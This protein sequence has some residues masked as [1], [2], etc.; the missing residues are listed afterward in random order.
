M[1][2]KIKKINLILF[3]SGIW[4]LAGFILLHRAYTWINLLSNTQLIVSLIIALF[5]AVIK[6]YFI[7]HKL[8]I[9]N[10]YRINNYEQEFI[11]ILKFHTVK[12]QLLIIL[13]IATG[14]ILRHS[15]Y[16]PKAFLMPIYIGIG[17]AMLYSATL[18]LLYVFKP[19]N[20]SPKN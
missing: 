10:I 15:P 9:K 16:I 7:F 3:T 13:M 5:L 19:Y 8:T 11:S 20:F 18:Y 2:P 6:A 14:S 17:M 12:D 4:L 1:I